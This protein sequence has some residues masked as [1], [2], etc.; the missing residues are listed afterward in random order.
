M[1]HAYDTGYARY[2]DLIYSDKDYDAECDY[3]EGIFCKYSPHPVKTMLELGCGTGGHAVPFARKGYKVQGIDLSE[4]MVTA[5]NSKAKEAKL[6]ATFRVMDIRQLKLDTTFDI[7]VSM[8][9]VMGYI[10]DTKDLLS[11]LNRI[12]KRLQS[13]SLFVFDI[14]NGLAVMRILPSVR[15]KTMTDKDLRIIRT[16]EPELDAFNHICKINYSLLVIRNNILNEEIKEIHN[17]RYFFPQEITHYLEDTGFK[18]LHICPFMEL[19]G[20]V[21]EN[22]WNITV[23]ASAI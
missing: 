18:V 7:C 16:A 4:A 2:Y 10:T 19:N 14:W 5:A 17:V 1:S 11:A 9:A 13:N 21:D 3:M 20:K 8:F 15:V 22:C 6:D 23:I 12:R